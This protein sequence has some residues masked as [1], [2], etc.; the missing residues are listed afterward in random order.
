MFSIGKSTKTNKMKTQDYNC[1]ILVDVP[2][3]EVFEGIGC[4]SGWWGTNFTGHSKK[5]DDVFTQR[6]GETFAS[7][8]IVE[9]IPDRKIVWKTID[10]YL[11]LLKDKKE[12]KDTSISWEIS[13]KGNMTEIS[14]THRGL[15]PEKECYP[16][17]VKGWNFFIKESLF[18]FLT[19]HKGLP[20]TG[21]H[22]RVSCGDRTYAG[23]LFS[24]NQP[25]PDVR[26]AY[27]YLDVRETNV[28]EVISSFSVHKLDKGSFT[29][30]ALKGE[31]YMLVEDRPLFG[32]TAPM[33]DLLR[34]VQ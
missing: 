13:R 25:L 11:D 1:L 32:S 29:T 16:D 19:E 14:M 27:L 30:Q 34:T 6:W 12:W 7:F 8:K 28:E 15:V 9:L 24:R 18:K 17:C 23:F 5:L 4:V 26:G 10:C 2:A 21:I 33:E 22:A 3:K 31:Y 20:T